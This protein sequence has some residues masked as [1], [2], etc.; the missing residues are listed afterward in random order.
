MQGRVLGLHVQAA[1]VRHAERLLAVQGHHHHF[2]L[3]CALVAGAL[4]SQLPGPS[5]EVPGWRSGGDST[6]K[7]CSAATASWLC[8]PSPGRRLLSCVA[9]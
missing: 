3:R 6:A 7:L 4:W 1:G 5:G 2:P 8:S 9:C